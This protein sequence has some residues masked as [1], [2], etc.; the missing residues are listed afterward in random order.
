VY[1][2]GDW[3]VSPTVE[4]AVSGGRRAGEAVVADLKG[5]GR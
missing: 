2:A 4:G 1:V 3:W 5:G